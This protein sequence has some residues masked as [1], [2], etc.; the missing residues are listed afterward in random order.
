MT[1]TSARTTRVLRVLGVV[2]LILAAMVLYQE[3]HFRAE[4]RKLR[5]ADHALT[6]C[7]AE[8]FQ[9]LAAALSTRAQI[10]DTERQADSIERQATRRLLSVS[11]DPYPPDPA[12]ADFQEAVQGYLRALQ[13]ADVIRSRAVAERDQNPLPE[14]P[15]G[16]CADEVSQGAK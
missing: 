8:N 10:A 7:L 15:D 6:L 11:V 2:V 1:P 12:S 5:E 14:Y 16:V 9:D 3:Q 13:R 4:D